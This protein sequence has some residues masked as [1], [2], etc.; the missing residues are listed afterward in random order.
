MMFHWFAYVL[1]LW[2]L[3]LVEFGGFIVLLFSLCL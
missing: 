3:G 1:W 2:D